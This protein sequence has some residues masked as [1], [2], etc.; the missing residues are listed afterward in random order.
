MPFIADLHTHSHLS[1][2]TSKE[3]TLEGMHYWAQLKGVRV[4]ATGD[5]THPAWQDDIKS[6]LIE[7]GPGLFRLHPDLAAAVDADV[8]ASCRAPVDFMITGEI[9]SIYKRDGACRKVHSLLMVPDVA[10][11]DK[12][13]AR[14]AALGNV[15]SDGRPILGLDPRHILEIAL[16]ANPNAYLVPAHIWT[17]WFSMLGSKSGFNSIQECFGDLSPHIFAAET[18]LSSDPPMNWRVSGLDPVS[19]ISNSDCHSPSNLGRNAN[20]FLC[21]PDFFA[22]RNALKSRDLSQF[23]G[24]LDMFPEEGKY[25]ADGHRA[26]GVCLEPEESRAL[27]DLCPTCG[28]PLV[29]G[30][31]HRVVELAD[32]P[33]GFVPPGSPPCEHI[34]PLDELLAELL[35]CG[36]Q[37]VKVDRAYHELLRRFGSEFTLL[38]DVDPDALRQVVPPFLDEAIRRVR[39]E[40]V[41]RQPG[42]DG[43]YGVI[44]VF[45]A[46]EKDELKKQ[47][48]FFAMPAESADK[49]KRKLKKKIGVK[50]SAPDY[51]FKEAGAEASRQ[52]RSANAQ[53]PAAAGPTPAPAAI[54]TT[55]TAPDILSALT[56]EQRQAAT[57]VD[58]PAII[59]AGPGTGKTRTLTHRIAWLVAEKNVDPRTILAITFTNRAAGE[60]RRRLQTLLGDNAQQVTVSTFHA[61]CLA[62]LR[63]C[64]AEVGVPPDFAVIDAD[65]ELEL[66]IAAGFSRRDAAGNLGRIE[67]KRALAED[68]S[69][70]PGYI[71][72]QAAEATQG[73]VAM[74]DLIPRWLAWARSA[75]DRVQSLGFDWVCVDEY[76]D[77]N[78]AQYEMVKQLCPTGKGLCVIGDPD[79]AI[80]GFRG[81]DVRFFLQFAAD[82]PDARVFSL[83][84]NYRSSATVVRASGQV[85]NPVRTAMSVQ[86]ESVGARGI[87]IRFH[88]AATAA[89][90]AEYIT[91]EIEHWLGGTS[92]FSRDSDRVA[93]GEN[94]VVGLSDIAILVRLRAVL[95]P[96][97]EALTRLGLPVQVV[98]DQSFLA[99]PGAREVIRWLGHA[100][101]GQAAAPAADIIRTLSEPPA[102]FNANALDAY[103]ECRRL[104]TVFRGSWQAFMDG[105]VLRQEPDRYEIQAQRIT[106]MT[107]HA[108]KGL[109]F[110]V[111]FIAGCEQVLIPWQRP[112]APESLDEERRL[113]YVGMT[114]AERVLYLTHAR[115]RSMFGKTAPCQPSPFLADIEAALRDVR[116]S[117]LMRP[118]SR[119]VQMEFNF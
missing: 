9:S 46:G 77:V 64:A 96:L 118:R 74:D 82:Y 28:K 84:R 35:E 102:S 61:F 94:G 91:H 29:L 30:V 56:E 105:L 2:A 71:Q 59:V 114:R 53:G 49:P 65:T 79:Q 40:Q 72:L 66:H 98:G 100:A 12:I 106:L 97:V 6:K 24:T 67:Q 41:I 48:V 16:E 60:M 90:E 55:V 63:R 14:L 85:V 26:C 18:G 19:L 52:T 42:Y 5:F 110:P 99:V 95:P 93:E 4:V 51:T 20:R 57:G 13:Q 83:S 23:G 109:E 112:G 108:A 58:A 69:D 103:Q 15:K 38:R 70:V 22:M 7:S 116:A 47:G 86:A 32:R 50:E 80:Y 117:A 44:R 73:V 25:H 33:K 10:A 39:R 54:T 88:E 75:P 17:P 31:L 78:R 87:S 89:A 1:R 36:A 62:G 34:V 113:L 45:N 21:E 104:A 11:M 8:P 107:L 81:S 119:N 115:Q 76:Q 101:Q 92:L 37:S 68:P 3:C 27:Q 43:E 111:V